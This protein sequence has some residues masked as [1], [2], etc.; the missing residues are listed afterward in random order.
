MAADNTPQAPPAETGHGARAKP[1]ATGLGLLLPSLWIIGLTLAL[2]AVGLGAGYGA[3]TTEAGSRWLLHKLPY[4]QVDGFRGALLGDRWQAQRLVYSWAKGQSTLTLEEV[5][6]QGLRWAWRGLSPELASAPKAW[7]ALH[8]KSLTV[9]KATLRNAPASGQAPKL[10]DSLALP[11]QIEI[12]AVTLGEFQIDAL[13]PVQQLAAQGLVLDSRSGQRWRVQG[14]QGQWWGLVMDG[15]ASLAHQAP[16][17]ASAQASL[18]PLQDGDSP[19]W[20]AVVRAEGPFEQLDVTA[21]LRGVPQT[22]PGVANAAPSLELSAQVLPLK[23][24][25]LGLL[26][27]KTEA[28]DLNALQAQ[29]PRTSLNGTAEIASRGLNAPVTAR[30]QLANAAPGRWDQG[31]LPVAQV[32]IDLAG[33]VDQR[34]QVT[35][36]RLE[37]LLADAPGSAGAAGRVT[38]RADWR[39]HI[40]TLDTQ[41]LDVQPQRLDQRAAGMRLS[42]PVAVSISG[43]AS[44]DPA[45]KPA[46]TPWQAK[47]KLDLEGLLLNLAKGNSPPVKLQLEATASAARVDVSQASAK[48]GAATATL[49]GS[50]QRAPGAEWALASTGALQ[51]FDPT[52]WLPGEPGSAWRQGPHRLSGQWQFDVRLPPDSVRLLQTAPLNL[53]QRLAGDGTLRVDDSL[54]AGVPVSVDARLAYSP[55]VVSSSGSASL[56]AEVKLGGNTLSVEGQGQPAGDG[57]ADRLKLELQADQ[58]ATLAPLLRLYPEA[59]A[60]APSKGSASVELQASG[61]WPTLRTEGSS[62]VQQLQAGRLA[63]RTGQLDWQLDSGRNQPLALTLDVSGVA[64]GT[65]RAERL[66]GTLRGTQGRHAIDIDALV[67]VAPAGTAAVLLGQANRPGGTRAQLRA[68]GSWSPDAGSG[69]RWRATVE[70]LLAAAWDGKSEL[71]TLK[72]GAA[73]APAAAAATTPSAP[74]ATTNPPTLWLEASDLRVDLQFNADGNLLAVRAP[75]GRMRLAESAVVRW[76]DVTVDLQGSSPRIEL[77][78]TAEPFNVAPLLSRLLPDMGWAGDLRLGGRVVVRAAERF[79]ADLT[80][81]RTDGDLLLVDGDNTL[82]L[83]LTELRAALSAHDGVWTFT[84]A[85]SGKT[86][87]ELRGSVVARTTASARWPTPDAAL[88]GQ[89]VLRVGDIGIWNNWVPPGWR[90]TG[91]VSGA[92]DVSGRFGQPRYTGALIGQRLG[93]RNL[94][95]GVNLGDG[96]VTIRLAGDSAQ[97]ETFALRGGDG[98]LSVRGS[99]TWGAGLSTQLQ[100]KAENFRVLGRVDRQIVASGAATLRHTPELLRLDGNVTINEGLVDAS[101]AN[102]PS[103]DDDVV[104]RRTSI[105][106]QPGEDAVPVAA[107]RGSD[108]AVNLGVD[109]GQKMRVRGYGLDTLLRGQLRVTTPNNRLALNGNINTEG[110]TYVAYGQRLEIERGI[111]AFRG[112]YNNPRLDILALRP[113]IDNRVGVSISGTALAPR[114]R[115]FSEP[116]LSDNEKLSW[117]V[118]GRAPDNLGRTDTAVLQRAAVALL[119]GDGEAPTDTMLRNLGIDDLSIRQGDGEVRETVISLGKQLSQRWYV[120][121]ERGV[122]ATQGTFQLIYRIAR[123]FTLRA[124]SGLENSLD[125]IWVWRRGET[126]AVPEGSVRKSITVPP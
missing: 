28:L 118:L 17:S 88:Q 104:V 62:R 73:L 74:T 51:G 95:E 7:G 111:L 98:T 124:Q 11:L 75:A 24:W 126:P 54:L 81:E 37:L 29:A 52:A 122:N 6:A 119:A 30:V 65:Q 13:A 113:K 103:L 8:A 71:N 66:R 61:R 108:I 44:P 9:S 58:L 60:W 15:S 26:N 90:M 69:G 121:Y 39:G 16:H 53:V 21:T 56:N 49:S 87:G 50:L 70:R 25:P 78:A 91:E 89:L 20:A 27:L 5:D 64:L 22:G 46:P 97:I 79:D 82:T 10:P 59:A 99:A 116:E 2:V 123:R 40:L 33:R 3:L 41:L 83:G 32:S 14:I 109:L 100:L 94:L 106:E 92:A 31:R 1:V 86:L 107:K 45:A 93:I 80:L 85:F 110:G 36:P 115:L 96:E 43:L 101:R 55:G 114:V 23:T 38:G 117:L 72:P 102:A 77:T 84:P 125:M 112:G 63:V 4:I 57:L 68:Q 76:D 42:G 67:P 120:G 48:T 47:L 34:N 18:R 19:R 12:D 105:E 35:A